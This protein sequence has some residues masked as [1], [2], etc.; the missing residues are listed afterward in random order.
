MNRR[1]IQM[2]DRVDEIIVKVTNDAVGIAA[3]CAR[4]E[5]S[6]FH[7]IWLLKHET[8]IEGEALTDRAGCEGRV[9]TLR[10]LSYFGGFEHVSM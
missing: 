9:A 3:G 4:E 7:I 8:G 1:W 10:G 5:D 2:V 6:A